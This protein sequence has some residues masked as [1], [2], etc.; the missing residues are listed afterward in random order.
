M[1]R[2]LVGQVGIAWER[3][4]RPGRVGVSGRWGE[5]DGV[6]WAGKTAVPRAIF[7]YW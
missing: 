3:M 5:G 4:G 7:N 1:Y 6:W 2:G